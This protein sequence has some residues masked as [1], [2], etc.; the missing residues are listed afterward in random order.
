MA[1]VYVEFGSYGIIDD[2]EVTQDMTEDDIN[3][4][5]WEIVKEFAC[6]EWSY[7]IENDEEY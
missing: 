2:F 7:Y 3:Q 5:A 4:T 1:R 6:T